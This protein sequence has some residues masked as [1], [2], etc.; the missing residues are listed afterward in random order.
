[1][2][3]HLKTVSEISMATHIAFYTEPLS[4]DFAQNETRPLTTYPVVHICGNRHQA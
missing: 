2:S 4:S 3:A 1:M